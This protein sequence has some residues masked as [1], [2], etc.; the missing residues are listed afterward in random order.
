MNL[1]DDATKLFILKQLEESGDV[2]SAIAAVG[3][4]R[5]TFNRSR[6]EDENWDEQIFQAQQIFIRK[7]EAEAVRRATEGWEENRVT[8][9]GDHYTVR[10][11]SDALLL[12]LLK[13][14]N[15]VKYA[16]HKVVETH[17]DKPQSVNWSKLSPEE[18]DAIRLMLE[19]ATAEEDNRNGPQ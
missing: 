2:E 15:K 6:K 16:D 10:K 7:L 5:R 9:K 13:A 11:F 17:T 14:N 3:V 19:K 18:Q 4:S 12:A 1:I 8:N